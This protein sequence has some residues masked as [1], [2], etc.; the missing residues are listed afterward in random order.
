MASAQPSQR[1]KLRH[2]I[3][4]VFALSIGIWESGQAIAAEAPLTPD[5]IAYY[6]SGDENA[7]VRL[8]I[9]MTHT[10]HL[11]AAETLLK[12]FPLQGKLAE[13]RTLF[14][15]G[16]I[17]ENRGQLNAS[18]VKFRSAL[19]NDPKL[20][21]VR[22]ELAQVLA[23]LDETDSA[24]HH[25]ELLVAEAPSPEQAAGIRSFMQ[26][27]DANH[28]L[29]FSGFVAVA[30]STNINLGSSHDTVYAP[31]LGGV[32]G[33][34]SS[35]QIA[36]ANQKQSGT[37]ITA[38]ANLGF[39]HHLGDHF[40][41][42]LAAGAVGTYYP[43][44]SAA[45]L[46]LS[47]SAELRYLTTTGYLGLGGI[48]SETIDPVNRALAYTSYGLR[49]SFETMLT[50]RDQLAGS[51]TFE[52]RNYPGGPA[53]NGTALMLS[54]VLTHAI[55]SS[56]NVALILGYENVN[57]QIDFNSYHDGTLGLGFYK[58]L[59]HGITLEGQATARF[60]GFD[61]VNPLALVTRTDENYTGSLTLT[62]RDWYF[63]GLAPSLN[64]TYTRNVSN[65]AVYDYDSHAVD[66]RLTKKF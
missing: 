45:T 55:D 51:A 21:M 8:L 9:E 3:G 34:G 25:L 57:Q 50:Q 53:S 24:K 7:R 19:A 35:W 37:G 54:S 62:K 33:A 41:G 4:A 58:E 30:P 56:S 16:L 26:Q 28:P 59:P 32:G 23:R 61:G 1:K 5:Q 43:T 12:R 14:L 13:N 42:V 10:G 66:V 29:K 6:Q 15:E 39:A 38:G 44:L 40:Q 22:A 47:Q 63:L 48:S 18:T 31:G 64:Y 46:G 20:T 60:A 52:F 36:P 65:I 17:L 49:G 11:D 2:F 27:L